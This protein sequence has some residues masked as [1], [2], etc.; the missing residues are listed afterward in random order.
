MEQAR[1]GKVF[2]MGAGPGDPEL[3]TVKG[4]RCLRKA[5]IVLYDRLAA[6]E[7]L[8]ETHSSALRIFV[9]KEP[10]HHTF[11]QHEINALL[12]SYAREGKLV[13]RLKGGD[14]YVFGRGGEEALALQQAGIPFEIIPGITSAIAVPAAAGIPVTHR[15]YASSFTIVTGHEA[16]S[17]DEGHNVNWE[18]LAALGGTIVVLMGVRALPRLTQR[19]IEAGMDSHMPAAIIQEGT[20]SQQRTLVATLASIADKA[21]E[22]QFANPALTII[23]EVV[24]LSQQL[25]ELTA[26]P[27]IQNLFLSR[28]S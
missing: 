10:H 13:V 26:H 15:A 27:E 12:V 23:G 16:S 8:E 24:S 3:I 2:L 17:P 18:A 1:L 25:Q 22:Q 21:R 5:D 4:L 11:K 19:M 14:P 20:T 6:P 28:A 7:L 9:G